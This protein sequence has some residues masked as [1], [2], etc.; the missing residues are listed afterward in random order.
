MQL[1][2]IFHSIYLIV[3]TLLIWFWATSP[4]LNPYNLQLTG[5]LVLLYFGLRVFMRPT[6]QRRMNIITVIILNAVCLLLIFSTGG[7]LSPLFFL[8]DFLL[9][10]LALIFEPVQAGIISVLLAGLFAWQSRSVMST[11]QLVNIAALLLM[12]P[13]AVLFSRNYLEN[14]ANQGKIYLL[15]KTI[16]EE[17]SDS[18]LWISTQA[19]P[20]L[21]SVLNA[22]TDLVIF[23]NSKGHEYILP[24]GFL[25]KIKTIQKDLITLYSAT[26]VL[27]KNI[28]ETSDNIDI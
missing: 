19:K 21:V 20:S 6:N 4:I 23:F 2:F 25:E 12:S 16:K 14:L 11:N 27:E 9:F 18:L 5:V 13:I 8:L 22:I 15:K 3:S 28:K 24:K 17:E 10:A 7:V 1:V 26:N